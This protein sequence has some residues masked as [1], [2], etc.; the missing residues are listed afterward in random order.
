MRPALEYSWVRLE[1][2]LSDGLQLDLPKGRDYVRPI[3]NARLF[4]AKRLR[5]PPLGAEVRYCFFLQHAI[6]IANEI[7]MSIARAIKIQKKIAGMGTVREDGRASRRQPDVNTIGGRVQM[8]REARQWSQGTLAKS[9]GIA[10]ATLANFE[11]GRT[12]GGLALTLSK[13]ARALGVDPE[14]LRTGKGDPTRHLD[15]ETAEE[16]ALLIYRALSED[17]RSAWMAAGRAMVA[18]KPKK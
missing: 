3:G 17:A 5:Y 15:A 4:D 8:L 12:R 13:I 10:Q 11:R 9:A 14:W 1:L 2:S 6:I 18:A 16:E 7:E